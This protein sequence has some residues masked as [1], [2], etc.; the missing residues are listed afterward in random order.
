MMEGNLGRFKK[1]PKKYFPI[2][3][4][5]EISQGCVQNISSKNLTSSTAIPKWP[6]PVPISYEWTP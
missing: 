3:R 5:C 4:I 1:K 6:K 2:L